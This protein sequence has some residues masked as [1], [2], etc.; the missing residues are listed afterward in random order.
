MRVKDGGTG[1]TPERL[2]ELSEELE[3]L[4]SDAHELEER[5]SENIVKLME[6]I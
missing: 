2:G 5:I 4:N 3:K 1:L 6:M